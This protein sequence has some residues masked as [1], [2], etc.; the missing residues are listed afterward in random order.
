MKGSSTLP[1]F[2]GEAR[3]L[4]PERSSQTGLQLFHLDGAK[5]KQPAPSGWNSVDGF[6]KRLVF[7]P[8]ALLP[9]ANS[10]T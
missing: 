7:R 4:S 2:D 3:C 9:G 8:C 1:D 5:L 6:R 10:P